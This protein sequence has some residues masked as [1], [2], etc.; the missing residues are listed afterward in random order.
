M[1]IPG[2]CRENVNPETV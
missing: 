2:Y 1:L